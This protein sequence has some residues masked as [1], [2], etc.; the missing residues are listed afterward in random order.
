MPAD[1]AAACAV[2]SD[3]E[4]MARSSTSGLDSMAGITCSVPIL[5]VPNT[6]H[7][8]GFMFIGPIQ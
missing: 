5:A 2:G 4:A 6:P 3:R 1:R 7:T 8:T